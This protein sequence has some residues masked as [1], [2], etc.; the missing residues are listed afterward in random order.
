M[1]GVFVGA[2]AP[3]A[4]VMDVVP[5]DSAVDLSTVSV[6][7]FKVQLEGGAEVTWSASL[8]NQ[9]ATTLTLTHTFTESDTTTAGSGKYVVFAQLT[10]PSGTVET[11]R[12][13][14]PVFDKFHV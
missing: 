4:Y 10:I 12:V 3:Q 13:L 1:I 14:L 5:G 9:T 6:A 11:D 7:I 2:K 8:S